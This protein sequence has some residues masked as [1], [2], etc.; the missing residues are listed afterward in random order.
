MK[1][2]KTKM[3][4]VVLAVAGLNLTVV[5]EGEER[6]VSEV[7]TGI[8]QNSPLYARMCYQRGLRLY[9]G[10]GCDRDLP[11]AVEAFRQ[12]AEMGYAEA[13]EMLA[14]CY[15]NGHGVE[16]DMN[17]AVEWRERAANH[18]R[19]HAMFMMGV[20][21]HSGMGGVVDASEACY[22]F[23]MAAQHGV[24]DPN[25]DSGL[26]ESEGCG[27]EASLA[28]IVNKAESGDVDAI[29]WYS[30]CFAYG[31]GVPR[32]D[33]AALELL[34]EAAS[35]GHSLSKCLVGCAMW[36]GWLPGGQDAGLELV[37]KAAEEGCTTAY[38]YL[39]NLEQTG[40]L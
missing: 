39:E 19:A 23:R 15:H 24:G 30:C 18:G 17:L 35:L 13:E 26:D 7:L 31:W 6:D 10:R 8:S 32:D 2:N 3:L 21:R 16:Q 29:Y 40:W 5:A 36:Y 22:W 9:Y 38:Q 37:I 28:W 11:A 4:L 27:L 33:A 34:I 20:Y 12:A 1:I 25:F 14:T